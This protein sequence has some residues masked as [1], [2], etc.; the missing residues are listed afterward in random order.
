MKMLVAS[1]IR[2]LVADALLHA[3]QCKEHGLLWLA[4]LWWATACRIVMDSAS[5][6]EEAGVMAT[7][8]SQDPGA[9]G[10]SYFDLL[11]LSVDD[12]A[13]IDSCI[14]VPL[15]SQVAAYCMAAYAARTGG[16]RQREVHARLTQP[17][18]EFFQDRM[19]AEFDE[20]FE[21]LG[22]KPGDLIWWPEHEMYGVVSIEDCDP[23]LRLCILAQL[24]LE[25][26]A[27]EW[28]PA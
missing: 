25:E 14:P 3:E 15:L 10:E 17:C 8:E 11:H 26:L 1:E 16:L 7:I 18:D 19:Q 5:W 20:K 27:D 21:E 2:N 4:D 9:R 13:G 22:L 28:P 6:A 23:E 24:R 12:L